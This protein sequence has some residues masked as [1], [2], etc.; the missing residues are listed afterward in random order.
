MKVAMVTPMSPESAIADV[1][2]QAIPRMS[3]AC[4]VEVWC[5]E[6]PEY[7]PCPVPVTPYSEADQD[8]LSAL[9]AY[10]L[11][12]YVLGNS[13]YHS[14]ILP[15]ARAL[16]G[17]VVLHDVALTDM[18]RHSASVRDVLDVVARRVADD[19]TPADAEIFRRGLHPD[20]SV[21]WLQFSQHITMSDYAIETS[22]G[23]VVHSQWHA[24]LVDGR[25]LGEVTVAPLPVPSPRVGFDV[26]QQTDAADHLHALPDEAVL[27]VTVGAANANRRIDALLEAISSD[28]LL[29]RVH[30]W[31]VGPTH[32]V[33]GQE[34][35]A[36]AAALGLADRFAVTGAVSDDLLHEI[37]ERAD[38]AAAL[39]DPV[40]EGQSAS[41]YTQ[42][43]AGLPLIVLDHAHY[44]ELPDDVAVKVETDTIV[45]SLR[46]ALRRLVDN[47]RE[48]VER[49][50][51]GREYVLSSRHGDAY[52][53]KILEGVQLAQ[54][55]RP[56]V[57]TTMDLAER[58]RQ[59]G[60][61]GHSA[62]TTLVSDFAFELFDLE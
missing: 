34:L 40:L 56:L 14:H 12:V 45:P 54:V 47:G 3:E 51:R 8:T 20:G 61:S 4:D 2:M 30:L 24:G 33:Y 28:P 27:V 50:A 41:V 22:L 38:L 62:I 26:N 60:L 39:R 19:A 16:P 29:S 44:A 46:N 1:M 52:A 53:E 5:P 13:P 59:T 48:R 7:R 35:R 11:V 21:G 25:T 18:V 31:S 36:R 55:S 15:L 23:V 32:E 10:D 43:L 37:L 57:R 17:L 49:G 58:L 9:A 6:A 42:M